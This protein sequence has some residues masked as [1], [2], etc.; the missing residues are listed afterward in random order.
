MPLPNEDR[1]E[2]SLE[3]GT[4]DLT[5]GFDPQAIPSGIPEEIASG[6]VIEAISDTP[7]T[8][9]GEVYIQLG[10]IHQESYS[11]SVKTPTEIN[12]D[13]AML[14]PQSG[15]DQGVPSQYSCLIPEYENLHIS[16]LRRIKIIQEI[17][18]KGN[19]I[20]KVFFPIALFVSVAMSATDSIIT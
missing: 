10:H 20:T 19:G 1:K 17:G 6:Q 8:S 15:E 5:S 13:T 14:D 2:Y 11:N 9:T 18:K 12:L 3:S 4:Q 7:I 16:G